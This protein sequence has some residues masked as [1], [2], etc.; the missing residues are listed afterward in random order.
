VPK[1]PD[2][3]QIENELSATLRMKV[4]I[5]HKAGDEGGKISIS[6]KS[7]DQLDDLLRALAGN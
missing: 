3:V 6:Y 5:D 4:T 2:T 7:L 1:D